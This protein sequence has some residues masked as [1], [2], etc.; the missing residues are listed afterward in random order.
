ML[1]YEAR[2]EPVIAPRRGLRIIDIG[3]HA[4]LRDQQGHLR[5]AYGFAPGDIALLRP[6]GYLAVLTHDESSA[7][8][9]AYI[10]RSLH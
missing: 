10:G 3:Q 8:L 2:S 1:R 7:A 6:D 4:A 5:T 9:A